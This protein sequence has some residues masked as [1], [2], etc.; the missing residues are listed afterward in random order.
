M[1]AA[2]V[3]LGVFLYDLFFYPFHLS[4]HRAK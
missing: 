3:V 4:F 1:S 2:Q